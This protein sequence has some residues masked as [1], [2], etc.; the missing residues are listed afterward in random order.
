MVKASCVTAP[1]ILGN[2]QGCS[3]AEPGGP[4]RLTFAPRRLENHSFFQRNHMLGILD[5][6]GSEHLAPF[7]FS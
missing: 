3:L 4:W 1:N 6:T 2:N 7:N 5:F